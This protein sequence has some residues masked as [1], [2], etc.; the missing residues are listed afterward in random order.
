MIRSNP[1]G[2]AVGDV[3]AVRFGIVR[4]GVV[5]GTTEAIMSSSASGRFGALARGQVA[6]AIGAGR[7]SIGA[8]TS[9]SRRQDHSRITPIG[10]QP[11]GD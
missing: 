6:A 9:P 8:G 1:P 5:G 7:Q 3:R 4:L 11:V 2:A 10:C